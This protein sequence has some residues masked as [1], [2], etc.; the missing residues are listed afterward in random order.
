MKA[1]MPDWPAIA[2]GH[3]LEKQRLQD[4]NAKIAK[5]LSAALDDPNVCQ[6]M[7]ADIREWFR[8]QEYNS[9]LSIG[10][11]IEPNVR[12]ENIAAMLRRMIWMARK[13]TGDTSMKAL[14][15][16]AQQLLR[17]YGLQGTPVR[18]ELDNFAMPIQEP[19]R[20]KLG[21]Q[22]P[23]CHGVRVTPQPRQPHDPHRYQCEECGCQWQGEG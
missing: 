9:S 2:T 14:A 3:C 12:I 11:A 4:G 17:Q 5:W 7:K 18:R 20:I 16:N 8:C 19:E 6:E 21:F 22:C 10:A 23:E 13:E 1:T 15:G